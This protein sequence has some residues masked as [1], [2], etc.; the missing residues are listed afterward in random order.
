MI[1]MR[2]PK[3]KY[4]FKSYTHL[5]YVRVLLL[6]PH[7]RP[8]LASQSHEFLQLLPPVNGATI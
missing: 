8:L 5:L 4:N 1:F 6:L 7:E 3:Y 2:E